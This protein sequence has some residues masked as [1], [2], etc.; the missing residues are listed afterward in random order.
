MSS[1]TI[2]DARKSYGRIEAIK[3]ISVDMADGEFVI[4]VQKVYRRRGFTHIK[5]RSESCGRAF[6]L[7]SVGIFLLFLAPPDR[8]PR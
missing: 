8:G 6:P 1:V 5:T 3:G 2:R 7:G 4:P